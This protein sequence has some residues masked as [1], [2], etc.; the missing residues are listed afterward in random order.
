MS[1]RGSVW[2]I[3][4]QIQGVRVCKSLDT[5]HLEIAIQRFN[6]I[7]AAR[8]WI[9]ASKSWRENVAAMEADKTS[10]IYVTHDRLK[11]RGKASKKGCS[12][13]VSELSLILVRADGR[14][15]V[16]GIPFSNDVPTG[17]KIAPFYMSVDRIRNDRGYHFDNCRVVCLA[18]NLA[19]R[20]WGHGVMVTIAEAMMYQHLK[21]KFGIVPQTGPAKRD[22]G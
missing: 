10:W 4:K 14:C 1:F 18:V 11:K 19:M 13:T 7:V 6:E 5:P 16:T 9:E 22:K 15:E 3:D 21:S 17:A 8:S 2:H 20:D 12:I